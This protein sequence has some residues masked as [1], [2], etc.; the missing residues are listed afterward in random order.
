M[1]YSN[2][3]IPIRLTR[4]TDHPKEYLCITGNLFYIGLQKIRQDVT[5]RGMNLENYREYCLS[6]GEDAGSIVLPP[7]VLN[8]RYVMLHNG[9]SGTLYRLKGTGPRFMSKKDLEKKGFTDLGHD[10]YLV[11]AFDNNKSQEYDKLPSL[12]RGKNTSKPWYATWEELI[13]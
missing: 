4:E 6:M 10:Y 3:I 2:A 7:K 1:S 9:T 11:Y 8:A 12:G 5:Y 13:H